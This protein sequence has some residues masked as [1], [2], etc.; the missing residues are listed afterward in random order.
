MDNVYPVTDR[1]D[2]IVYTG[3]LLNH[4]IECNDRLRLSIFGRIVHE[5]FA[6]P[7]NIVGKDVSTRANLIKNQ[8][9][10][11]DI[12][13]FIRIDIYYIVHLIEGGD[14]LFGIADM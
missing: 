13:P 6:A 10:V 12:F 3:I 14:Y 4:L 7:Q 2:H 5:N 9:I 11:L 8:I 1:D